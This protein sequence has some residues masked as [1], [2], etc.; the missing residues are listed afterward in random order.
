M[1]KL[2]IATT[3]FLLSLM[4]LTVQAQSKDIKIGK[5]ET[6]H[7]TI[8][9]QEKDLWIYVPNRDLSSLFD[10]GKYP[11]VYLL[12]GDEHFIPLMGM[13]QTLCSGDLNSSCPQM[14]L[15]GIKPGNRMNE[16]T[17]TKAGSLHA[18]KTIIEASGGGELFT[19]FMENELFPYIEKNYPTAP[20]RTLI[21][22]SVGG[23]F[24]I[25]T[26]A[27]HPNMFNN[28]VAI[29]PS[30]WWDNRKLVSDMKTA[31]STQSLAGKS[32]FVA[33]ANNMTSN[34][35][36]Q[37]VIKDTST[38]TNSI[39]SNLKLKA[40]LENDKVSKLRSKSHYYPDENH[41]TVPLIA[42]FEA[43]RW[44]FEPFR[45]QNREDYW[46]EEFD[47][48]S[49]I[50]LRFEKVSKLLGYHVIPPNLMAIDFGYPH[51]KD[52]HFKRAYEYFSYN[53]EL[54]PNSWISHD[55]MG[56]YYLA[57]NDKIKAKEEFLKALSIFRSPE[58]EKK[59]A[60]LE[61]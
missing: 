4:S 21:G 59:L 29:D 25:N 56:D 32:L 23:L 49:A 45:I 53:L 60:E 5:I 11:V 36:L 22:H 14:I 41:G 6:I 61:K 34:F 27:H 12:D 17:P 26:L 43:L 30:M 38:K 18:P 48:V 35:T 16:L 28:Y 10:Q 52:K 31:L 19:Q 47:G 40:I 55:V 33:I 20:H 39:R 42:E 51:L 3:A 57:T 44:L 2:L 24:V 50:K 9:N 37:S 46:E 8:L 58:T 15:V 54:Y 1:M 7:S 13:I